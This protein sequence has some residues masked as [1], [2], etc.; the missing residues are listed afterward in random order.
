MAEVNPARFWDPARFGGSELMLR[1]G[2]AAVLAPLAVGVAYLDG[3]LFVTFWIAAAIVVLWEWTSLVAASDRRPVL[4]S[5]GASVVLAV[6]L[7]AMTD[8]L[9]AGFYEARL[10]AAITVLAMGMLSVAVLTPREQRGWMACGIPYAGMLG[11]APV[12]LRSDHERGFLAVIVLFGIVWATDILAYFVG[13]TIG[14]P[15]LAPRFSPK[16]TWS[17]A[18]GGVLAGLLAAVVIA[19]LAGLTGLWTIAIIA[20]ILSI[21]AQAGDIFESMLKRRFGV[22][23]SSHLIP[24]HGG[25]MDR[26]DGFTAAAA[27]AALIGL[28]RGGLEAPARGLLLW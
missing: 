5:G 21:A 1:V 26:L 4:M 16:K 10:L 7:A 11:I 12:V 15:K 20:A 22:K 19:K 17:G 6:L 2:S 3:W 27:V 28:A 25:L 23:D 8:T 9:G 14:G 24:G 18:V 13:R